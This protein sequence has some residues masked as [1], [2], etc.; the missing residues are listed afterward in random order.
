MKTQNH[1]KS[2]IT[3]KCKKTIKLSKGPAGST[4]MERRSGDVMN[5]SRMMNSSTTHP[6]DP[7]LV[8]WNLHLGYL[9]ILSRLIRHAE[10]DVR[11]MSSQGYCL[12]LLNLN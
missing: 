2:K 7:T 11:C 9:I 8:C 6:L 10:L 5:E 1:R 3:R 4:I 12:I